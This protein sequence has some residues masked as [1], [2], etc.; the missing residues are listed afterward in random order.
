MTK[1]T[2]T[3]KIFTKDFERLKRYKLALGLPNYAETV[4]IIINLSEIQVKVE[5]GFV[6]VAE[7]KQRQLAP[8]K[9]NEFIQLGELKP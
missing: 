2:T 5:K 7:A 1:R 8:T 6:E 4:D 3:V 9:N